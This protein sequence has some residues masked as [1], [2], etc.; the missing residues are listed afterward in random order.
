MS[1]IKVE[2]KINNENK[3]C[4]GIMS[5]NK[6]TFKDEDTKFSIILGNEVVLKRSTNEY[7]LIITFGSLDTCTYNL[8]HYG[9][10][11]IDVKKIS[12]ENNKNNLKIKYEI[13]NEIYDFELNYEVIE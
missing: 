8:K 1:K 7:E 11:N 10:M 3:I 4:M 9:I 6:I 5:K 13:N 2:Y 12:L